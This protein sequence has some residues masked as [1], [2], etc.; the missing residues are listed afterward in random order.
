MQTIY[1][2]YGKAFRDLSM[3]VACIGYFDGVHLGHLALIE[4]CVKIAKEH[5]AIST[6]ITFEPDPWLVIKN[7]D[8]I[9]QL[10]SL[11]ERINK[12]KA[13]GIQQ[14]IV[15]KFTREL[16][17]LSKEAFVALLESFNLIN[18]VCGFDFHYGFRGEGNIETL[19]Q[20]ANFDISI[21]SKVTYDNFKISSTNIEQALEV[22]DI[23]LAN[24]YL[25][26]NYCVSGEV[27]YGAQLGRT[28]NFPT[29]NLKLGFNYK[30]PK[31]GVYLGLVESEGKTY[32]A[33]INIGHNPTFNYQRNISIEAHLLD[34]NGDLYG[35]AI[36]VCF[37]K[38]IRAEEKFSSKDALLTQLNKDLD[39]AIKYFA[40]RIK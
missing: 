4:D 18:L 38:R 31:T 21:I 15:L 35:K 33:L 20:D 22:G 17:N 40:E 32:N 29:A 11:E 36:K 30:I 2:E 3:R 24:Y 10:M 23:E 14:V 8:S 7:L 37:L 1:Y 19:K 13:Y 6:M 39:L 34:F 12:A 5:N 27:A 26:A 28:I 25:N 16:A 9:E